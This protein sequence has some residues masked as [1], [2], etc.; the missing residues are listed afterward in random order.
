MKRGHVNVVHADLVPQHEA[1][2][3]GVERL[4]GVSTGLYVM[5]KANAKELTQ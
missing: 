4:D 3:A 5:A 1:L 2:K